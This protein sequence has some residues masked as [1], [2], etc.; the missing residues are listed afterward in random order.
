[1]IIKRLKIIIC[2][3]P[4]IIILMTYGCSVLAIN[5][6]KQ[7]EPQLQVYLTSTPSISY[8]FECVSKQNPRESAIVLKIIDGDSILVDINGQDY[9]VR[10]IGINAPEYDGS[11]DAAACNST[12]INRELVG[13]KTIIMV[14][15]IREVD[16]YGRLLRF[17]FVDDYFV[18][19]ELVKRGAAEVFDYT[20]D[21]SCQKY[22]RSF[23]K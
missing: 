11:D 3:L 18:N 14:K 22:F 13:G 7:T 5:E 20:P 16:K 4:T 19:A 1:M 21:T 6:Q 12:S 17:V 10:Y 23:I 2:F 9:E 15:D 8:Q